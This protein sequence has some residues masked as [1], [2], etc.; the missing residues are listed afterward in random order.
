[1]L[2]RET[3]VT[4]IAVVN[5]DPDFLDLLTEL[6]QF[7]GYSAFVVREARGAFEQ[8]KQARPD[9]IV[10]DIRIGPDNDGWQIAECLTLDPSTRSI[11]VILCS[12]A[13]DD[14]QYRIPWLQKHG[15]GAVAKPFDLEDMLS[16]IREGLAGGTPI[17]G[18]D[19]GPEAVAG[20]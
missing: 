17:V 6:L 3:L 10:L 7:E 1:V 18:L 8:L 2:V 19:A 4:T 16:A 20:T 9:V 5:D 15:I 14:L 11:P 12:A 13:V